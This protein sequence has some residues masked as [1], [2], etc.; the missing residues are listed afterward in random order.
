MEQ[1]KALQNWLLRPIDASALAVFRIAFGVLMMYEV[2]KYFVHDRIYRYYVEPE[3]YFPYEFFWFL[4]PLP[5]PYMY[6][7]FVAMAVFALGIAL[8]LFYRTSATLFFLS[9]T[10]VFLLDK[11]QFNNHYYMISLLAFLFIMTNAHRCWSV[12][13]WFDSKAG[14][15]QI[16]AW[17]L[18]IF[19]AQVVIVYFYGGLAKLNP[20]WL[21][22]EP[23]RMWLANRSDYAYV[24]DWFLTESAAYFFS[25]GGLFFDLLIGFALLWRPTRWFAFAGVIV[26]NLTNNWLFSI[27]VFPFL[28][29]G[30]LALFG[31]H[32]WPRRLLRQVQPLQPAPKAWAYSSWALGF[33]AAYIAVQLLVPL[34]HFAI[35]G[36]PSWTEEGHRF[37]WHMKLRSKHGRIGITVIDPKTNQTWI[38]H[39]EEDLTPRQ[40]SKMADRPDMILQYAHHIARRFEA[41]GIED[42]I[43]KVE[44]H[45]SLNGRSYHRMIDPDY[46]LAEASFNP[47][48]HN[49]WILH[50]PDD[51]VLPILASQTNK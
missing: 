15:S 24:G 16:P 22:G 28:M 5:E 49:P 27:G 20:D 32:N 29:I 6:W 48:G 40:G 7:L 2:Y 4:S 42:P 44:S 25:Y 14:P 35:P 51:A 18:Y 45:V 47:F 36:N 39:A 38:V 13:R 46:N 26:F 41:A 30:A 17:H 21:M 43:V 3:F 11:T 37:A 8:G 34:R 10:Y 19:R 1:P 9:Y 50:L 33:V 12:D 31:D 23:M